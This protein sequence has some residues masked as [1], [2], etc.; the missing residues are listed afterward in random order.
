M[1]EGGRF[2]P[3]GIHPKNERDSRIR[4]TG[5]TIHDIAQ[6]KKKKNICGLIFTIYL[7]ILLGIF[8]RPVLF[9]LLNFLIFLDR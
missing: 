4:E 6:K 5:W 2:P 7:T 1:A 8:F 9:D 3:L